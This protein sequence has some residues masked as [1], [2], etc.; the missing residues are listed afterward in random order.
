MD[1]EE[2]KEYRVLYEQL[3]G[4]SEQKVDEYTRYLS[5]GALVLSLT[6][7]QNIVP[8]GNVDC[9]WLIFI[10]WGLLVLS[11]TSNFVSYFFTI[12]N[13]NK[14]I[15]EIDNQKDDWVKNAQKRNRT[16]K[17]INYCSAILSIFGII[18]ITI[19]VSLNINNYG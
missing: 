4:E 5:G 2:S 18:A 8:S 10:G 3:R 15:N 17:W 16:I 1:Q 7:I 14:A 9:Q 12:H 6:F 11:L 19:F 13:T